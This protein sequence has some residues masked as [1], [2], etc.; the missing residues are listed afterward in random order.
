[1]EYIIEKVNKYFFFTLTVTVTV[2]ATHIRGQKE[3]TTNA[4]LKKITQFIFEFYHHNVTHIR[5]QWHPS[6]ILMV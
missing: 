2:T 5:V 4:L 1:M 3:R 6:Y